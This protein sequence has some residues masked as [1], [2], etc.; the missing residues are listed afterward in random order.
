MPPPPPHSISKFEFRANHG[1]DVLFERS[2]S[3]GPREEDNGVLLLGAVALICTA[4]AFVPG[5][6]EPAPA[7]AA[8]G[9]DGSVT[10]SVGDLSQAGLNT[11]SVRVIV[12]FTPNTT[13]GER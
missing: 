4:I 5:L 1:T 3:M 10:R 2:Q 12:P 13:P 8:K 7:H 6:L 9:A 11:Q